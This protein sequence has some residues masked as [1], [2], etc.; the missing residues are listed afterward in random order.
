VGD[1]FLKWFLDNRGRSDLCKE[2]EITVHDGSWR[3]WEEFPEDER[4]SNFDPSDQK[5]VAVAKAHKKPCTIL[6]AADH[7][8]LHWNIHLNE[9][10]VI[11]EFLCKAELIALAEMKKSISN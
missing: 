11:V 1:K 4:L 9:A 5:F 2:V 3:L 6:Q 10:G 8:W 7:K